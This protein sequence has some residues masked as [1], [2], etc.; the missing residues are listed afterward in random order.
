MTDLQV[1]IYAAILIIITISIA[2][3]YRQVKHYKM[4]YEKKSYMKITEKMFEIMGAGVETKDKIKKL[5]DVIIKAYNIKYSSIVLY[6]GEK[7]KVQA[8][9]VEK[10]YIPS[11]AD[12][13]NQ[14]EFITKRGVSKYLTSHGHKSLIYKSAME[15]KIKSVLY[16]PI[17]HKNMYM[18]FFVLED[19]ESNAFEHISKDELLRIKHNIGVFLENIRF[20]ST[21]EIAENTDIQTGYYNNMYMY[22]NSRK[23]LSKYN[24]S[25]VTL[26]FLKNIPE[27][28]EEFGI[29][30][31]NKL[32]IKLSSLIK[33]VFQNESL[34]IRYSGRRLLIITP[35]KNAESIQPICEQ[36]LERA[37]NEYECVEDKKVSIDLHVLL[38]TVKKQSNIEKEIQKMVSYTNKIKDNNSIKI[39]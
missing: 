23:I 26:I 16:S 18:G 11:I 7:L 22:S 19:T 6:D 14:R 2:I 33:G 24:N 29:N 32:L 28:N 36:L 31:G 15:R 21:L 5:N 20:Q 12:M 35:D 39:L 38:H 4:I 10:E 13:V 3:L 34:F 37:K 25:C 1:I 9:N 17:Y 27:I 8:T 30:L